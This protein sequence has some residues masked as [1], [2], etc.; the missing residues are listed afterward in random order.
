M[1]DNALLGFGVVMVFLGAATAFL[2]LLRPAH[3]P[4]GVAKSLLVIEQ[5]RLDPTVPLT[6]LPASERLLRPAVRRLGRIGRRLTPIDT[7]VRLQRRL[8]LAGNP[9]GWSVERILA[10]KAGGLVTGVAFGVLVLTTGRLVLGLAWLV[11]AA[12]VGFWLPDV[13]LLNAGQKRQQ[14]LRKSVPDAL[15]ML[16]VCVEA[17]LGFDAGLAQVARNAEGPIAGEFARLLREMQIGKSRVV[18]FTDLAA[19]TTVPELRIFVSAL[20]QSDKLGIPLAGVLRE[21][22]AEMRVKR[23]QRAEEQ[24]QKVPVKILFPLLLCIFPALFVV[25]VGPGAIQI[26][27]SL[28]Q[29]P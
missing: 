23:R 25:L 17:G 15:D 26:A 5:M 29:T 8:D 19:R 13:L 16:T 11:G 27:H 10:C 14:A 4:S 21:Q 1:S 6:A 3:G 12:A 28:I 2:A 18:A 9:S 24:A 20:V 7:P 22:S